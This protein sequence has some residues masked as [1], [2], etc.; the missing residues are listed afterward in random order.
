VPYVDASASS[1]LPS[2]WQRAGVA[3]A[4]IMV[5]LA[6]AAIASLVWVSA[7]PGLLRAVAFNVM[8]IGGVSTVVVNGNPLLRFDGYYVLA[9]VLEMPNLQQRAQRFLGDLVNRHIFRVPLLQPVPANFYERAVMLIYAPVSFCYRIVV[10][11]G[12]SL[13]VAAHYFIAGIAM[14]LLTVGM[15]VVLPAGRALWKVAMGVQ[16]RACRARAVGF[17]FGAIAVV[18]AL[19]MLVPAPLHSTAEGVIWLPQDSIVRAGAD[20]FVLRVVAEPGAEVAKGDVLFTLEHP[21]AEAK[22]RVAAAR[23]DEL[24]AKYAAEW[25]NDR[26]AAAVTGFELNQAR[27][28]LV[29][30]TA[31]IG[32]QRVLAPSAGRFN[33]RGPVGDMPGSYVKLGQ[34][35]GYV[36][37]S[38][39]QVARVVVPQGDIGL[40]RDRLRSVV[41]RLA[42]RH[43]ELASRVLRAVPA[44][45]DELPSAA[46]NADN[47]GDIATDPRDGHGV[48]AFE[49]HFQFDVALPAADAALAESGF[50]SRVFVRFNYAWE[51]IGA[52]LYRRLRQGMLS[53]FET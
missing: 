5:E 12:V 45:D 36:T 25:V 16:Y 53:R 20:G 29:R 47:G 11:L 21:I 8:L 22:L 41:I 14:A 15:S 4:G 32:D 44:A 3:A 49:R 17:T 42:D 1:A 6:L 39:G 34:I 51:P 7:E 37:P 38:A 43:T 48:R 50:G 18:I 26:I 10:M 19:V 35:I 2:K 23:V 24:Q 28:E 13:F 52:S 40:V 33:A 27:A 46:L 9:D 30:E 31:R